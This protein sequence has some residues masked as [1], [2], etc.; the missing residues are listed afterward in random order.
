M[1]GKLVTVIFAAGLSACSSVDVHN[2]A[3]RPLVEDVE[4]PDYKQVAQQYWSQLSDAR[5]GQVLSLSG[6]NVRLT[7]SYVAA[8]G[9]RCLR[10]VDEQAPNEGMSKVA[11]R[12]PN[13]NSW[14]YANNVLASY[15][16]LLEK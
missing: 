15:R 3:Q 2:N 9:A 4:R 14:Y 1:N 13:N 11:C 10:F 5:V 12:N 6:H 8:S 7:K 16:S